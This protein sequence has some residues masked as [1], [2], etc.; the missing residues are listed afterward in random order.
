MGGTQGEAEAAN[1][2]TAAAAPVWRAYLRGQRWPSP[3][4]PG[5]GLTIRGSDGTD[6]LSACEE[7]GGRTAGDPRR[8]RTSWAARDARTVKLLTRA[9]MGW[10]QGRI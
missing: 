6:G 1:R 4:R 7:V 10:C 5:A 3:T 2:H 8:R 9:G